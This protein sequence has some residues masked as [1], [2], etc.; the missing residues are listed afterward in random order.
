MAAMHFIKM[1]KDEVLIVI[2]FMLSKTTK[3]RFMNSKFLDEAKLLEARWGQKSLLEGLD[4]RFTRASTAK[5]LECQRLH[6]ETGTWDCCDA[7]K[8]REK[9]DEIN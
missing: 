4:S 3:D 6:N 8:E 5:M 7:C 1:P 9:Q 2:L